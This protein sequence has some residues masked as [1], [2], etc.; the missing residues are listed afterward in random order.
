MSVGVVAG[1]GAG[2]GRTRG[3]AVL[4]RVLLGGMILALLPAALCAGLPAEDPERL[5]LV[6]AGFIARFPDFVA[7]PTA[8]ASGPPTFCLAGASELTLPLRSVVRHMHSGRARPRVRVVGA[9]PLPGGCRVLFIP[10]SRAGELEG[11]LGP[12]RGR[13]VLTV[14]D[15]PGFAERGVHLNLYQDGDRVGFEVNQT[16]ARRAGL[17]L[18]FRLLEMARLVDA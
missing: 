1:A 12:L 14:G 3:G 18:D 15:T 16:A 2:A 5:A 8:V 11:I 7:W 10:G 6:K 4:R 17:K 13:P 9:H